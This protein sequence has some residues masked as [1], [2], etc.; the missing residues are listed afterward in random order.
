MLGP[1]HL[2]NIYISKQS[3]RRPYCLGRQREQTHVWNRIWI[4]E[5]WQKC[6]PDLRVHLK[7]RSPGDT[8]KSYVSSVLRLCK[9]CKLFMIWSTDST[10]DLV[11]GTEVC[12]GVAFHQ[13]HTRCGM[14]LQR[15]VARRHA[16]W[17]RSCHQQRTKMPQPQNC[18]P[19]FNVVRTDVR[20]WTVGCFR[21]REVRVVHREVV[22]HQMGTETEGAHHVGACWSHRRHVWIDSVSPRVEVFELILSVWLLL[23]ACKGQQIVHLDGIHAAL[24]SRRNREKGS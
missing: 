1:S 21:G 24:R 15:V 3:C 6:V 10:G 17:H 16:N 18:Q 11:G 4:C 7:V 23:P 12:G 19:A 2:L 20:E 8:D 5:K 22:E 13:C 9:N 14:V